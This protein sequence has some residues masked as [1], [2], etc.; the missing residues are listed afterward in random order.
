[1]YQVQAQV[2]CTTG[3]GW[4]SSR[5][6]PTLAVPLAT[7]LRNAAEIV[8]DAVTTMRD[9]Q[10]AIRVHVAVLDTETDE[11]AAFVIEIG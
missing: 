1:M 5:Q 7:S 10:S 4:E 9:T 3:D 6:V 2:S 8:A 11:Y